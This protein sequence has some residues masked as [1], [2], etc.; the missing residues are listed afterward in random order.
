MTL[1]MV[2]TEKVAYEVWA[3]PQDAP[4]QGWFIARNSEQ[5][6]NAAKHWGMELEERAHNEAKMIEKMGAGGARYDTQVRRLTLTTKVIGR[7][8]K[9]NKPKT[10]RARSTR[11]NEQERERE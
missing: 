2:E 1:E 3:R 8:P 9:P 4:E 10:T 11:N 5:I 6:D 7:Y